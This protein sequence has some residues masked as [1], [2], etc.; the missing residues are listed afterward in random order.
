MLDALLIVWIAVLYFSLV[1]KL[2]YILLSFLVGKYTCSFLRFW[3]FH[4]RLHRQTNERKTLCPLF[5]FSEFGKRLA[6]DGPP[7][8]A[9]L[10]SRGK[11]DGHA[12]CSSPGP[13]PEHDYTNSRSGHPFEKNFSHEKKPKRR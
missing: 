7:R 5:K 1:L 8:P 9:K 13:G 12:R 3:F 11:N 10:K 4:A 2:I 6:G